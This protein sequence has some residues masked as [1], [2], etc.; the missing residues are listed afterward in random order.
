MQSVP[1]SLSWTP[2]QNDTGDNTFIIVVD[3]DHEVNETTWSNNN[4]T[5]EVCVGCGTY[6]FRLETRGL[7]GK[8][9]VFVDGNQA[10]TVGD[11]SPWE[12][13]YPVSESHKIAIEQCV[14]HGNSMRLCTSSYAWN[15]PETTGTEVT[16][17]LPQY[18][19]AITSSPKGAP[20]PWYS[21]PMDCPTADQACWYDPTT[22]PMLFIS[23]R[24]YQEFDNSA[25]WALTEV[26]L[27]G[28][29]LL[30]DLSSFQLVT[31]QPHNFEVNYARQYFLNMTSDYSTVVG[32]G[33]YNEHSFA[34]WKLQ[35][36][37]IQINSCDDSWWAVV[38]PPRVLSSSNGTAG[39]FEMS[40]PKVG[41]VLWSLDP[42]STLGAIILNVVIWGAAALAPSLISSDRVR[43]KKR[44]AIW[45]TAV[46]IL[47]LVYMI[48][49]FLS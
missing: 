18:L 24:V 14:A 12:R 25:R 4:A 46:S 32:S 5:T 35:K 47:L 40:R 19:V 31:N 10:G 45:A 11:A 37:S 41:R 49:A 2:E 30:L 17:Y 3:P 44:L 16:S 7:T 36:S 9:A 6:A 43:N 27:D 22:T 39:I 26:K 28:N 13:T 42:S 38:C 34:S 15:T 48:T 21:K 20:E 29:S 1:F 8:S 33:W 23:W